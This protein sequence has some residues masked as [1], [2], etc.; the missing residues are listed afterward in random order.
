MTNAATAVPGPSWTQLMQSQWGDPTTCESYGASP[1]KSASENTA[2]IQAALNNGGSISLTTPGT[3]Q[4]NDTL[5]ISA[6]TAFTLGAS[7]EIYL[8]DNTNKAMLMCDSDFFE[9]NH[10]NSCM[11]GGRRRNGDMGLSQFTRN[12]LCLAAWR[13]SVGI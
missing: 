8:A 3:Y 6:D 9:R 2:A 4:I 13:D 1:L 10:R 5:T 12:R 7:V 11:D